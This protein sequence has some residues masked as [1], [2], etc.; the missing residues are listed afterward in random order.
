MIDKLGFFS[1]NSIMGSYAY[2]HPISNKYYIAGAL[3]MGWYGFNFNSSDVVAVDAI[4]NTY[5][6]FIGNGSQSN[7][8]D[9]N[10]GIL[11]YGD[12]F[13]LGYSVYQIG[14]NQLRSDKRGVESSFSNA[15]LKM[16]HYLTGSYNFG[17]SD[18][19]DL[20]PSILLQFIDTAPLSFDLNLRAE[21]KKSIWIGISHR[22]EEGVVLSAGGV[23]D[24]WLKFGYAYDVST[25]RVSNISS[26]SNEI[27]LGLLLNR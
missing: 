10:A 24:G 27:V 12:E 20:T 25:S 26:G 1:R 4:D 6:D 9:I 15:S 8:F 2:H 5:S 14:Q 18:I 23:W 7:L 17:V 22:N 19:I 13:I 16:H 11:V 3:S 21:Y